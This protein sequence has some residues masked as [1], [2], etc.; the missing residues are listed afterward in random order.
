VYSL[1]WG[2]RRKNTPHSNASHTAPT[3]GPGARLSAYFLTPALSYFAAL[4]RSK[5]LRPPT[6]YPILC[7]HII[8]ARNHFYRR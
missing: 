7:G 4:P 3:G 2:R 6:A 1:P 8:P 5:P